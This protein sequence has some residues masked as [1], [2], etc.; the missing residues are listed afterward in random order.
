MNMDR[1]WAGAHIHTRIRAQ[2]YFPDLLKIVQKL[3]NVQKIGSWP[4]NQGVVRVT[5]WVAQENYISEI[6]PHHSTHESTLKIQEK[7]YPELLKIV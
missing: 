5:M 7:Y 3:K 2:I 4:K 6:S 1:G